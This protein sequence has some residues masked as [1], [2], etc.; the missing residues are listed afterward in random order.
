MANGCSDRQE[1]ARGGPPTVELRSLPGRLVMIVGPSGAG[2]DT[3]LRIAMAETR[4]RPEVVYARRWVTRAASADEDNVE[5]SAAEFA[6]ARQ[7]GA[8]ALSWSAH[9]H[10]YAIPRAIET[11]LEAGR[12]VVLNASRTVIDAARNTYGDVGVA[13]IHASAD[14]RARRLAARA[15]ESEAAILERLTSDASAVTI[16]P[17]DVMIVNEAAPQPAARRLVEFILRKPHEATHR[18][19]PGSREIA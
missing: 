2:K 4:A 11:D 18:E 14:V 12:T 9:G 16:G 8:F 6:A 10:S 17:D 13:Y 7:R 19:G 5:L 1:A 15:R 3:L